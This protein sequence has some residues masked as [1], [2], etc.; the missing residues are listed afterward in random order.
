MASLSERAIPDAVKRRAISIELPNAPPLSGLA[1]ASQPAP[2]RSFLESIFGG[3]VDMPAKVEPTTAEKR[4][5][6]AQILQNREGIAVPWDRSALGTKQELAAAI[7]RKNQPAPADTYYPGQGAAEDLSNGWAF[8]NQAIADTARA[9]PGFLS[10]AGSSIADF[11]QRPF[12]RTVEAAQAIG[13]LGRP[14][15][16]MAGMVADD[17][18]GSVEGAKRMR[19]P[20]GHVVHADHL[21]D[22]TAQGF[23]LRSQFEKLIE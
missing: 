15:A 22:A 18:Q 23:G 2:K 17:V 11:A 12:S 7:L 3:P 20:Q 10:A 1:E 8:G 21:G 19:G 9:V 4:A 6:I 14:I 5:A 16:D 13:S